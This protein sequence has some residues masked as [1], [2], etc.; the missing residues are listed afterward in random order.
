MFDMF[1]PKDAIYR[2]VHDKNTGLY[3]DAGF[4]ILYRDADL[5]HSAVLVMELQDFANI[6]DKT[7][8]KIMRHLG[9]VLQ[10]E[11][12]SIDSI[13]RIRDDRIAIIMARMSHDLK[14]VVEQKIERI[15]SKIVPDSVTV[16]VAFGDVVNGKDLFDSAQ[17]ALEKAKK[18]YMRMYMVV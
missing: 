7:V 11:F 17:H 16:G 4:Y 5:E 8:E 2:K 3:N 15:S 12:R 6:P 13:C 1:K 10:K 14:E 18:E 9:G